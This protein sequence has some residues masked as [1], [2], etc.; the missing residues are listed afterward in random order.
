M[1]RINYIVLLLACCLLT[2]TSCLDDLNTTPLEGGLLT[3]PEAAWKKA[4]TY[5][6]FV[7]KIY[8]CFAM[9]GNNGPNGLDDIVANDQGEATFLRSYWNLQQLTTDEAVCAWDDD[10]L[11]GLMF[12]NWT[13]GNRFTNLTYNRILMTIAYCNEYLRQTDNDKLAERN[14]DPALT[15]KIQ[16][17]RAEV[18]AIRAIKYFLLMDLFAN[19]PFV[20]E[21]MPVGVINQFPEQ[22]GRDFFFPRIES[23]LKAV[24]NQLPEKSA[25]TYGRMNNPTIWMV[26]AKMYLNAEVYI[27]EKKYTEAITYLTKITGAGYTLDPVY[28]NMFGADNDRSPEIIFPVVFDGQKTTSYGGTTYLMAGAYNPDDMEPEANFGL[29]QAWKGIRAKETLSALF[30]E[31]DKR[32]LFWTTGR[33]PE[34]ASLYDFNSGY[35]VV[36]YTNKK[37]D[38]TPGSNPAFPD[39]DFPFFRLADAY[40]MY[41]EAVLRGGEG[42]DRD[43]ALK[44]VNELQKRA[45][46]TEIKD[47]ELSLDFLLEERARELYWEGHR[48]T[49]L[50][51]FNKFT[52]NYRWPWKNGVYLGTTNI[53]DIY[54]L[55]PVPDTELSA[56]PNIKQNKGY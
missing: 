53:S 21:D 11:S 42:G 24:E 44:Y 7:A 17:Y 47:Y 13:S 54:K 46:I 52:A 5:E 3:T 39:T 22:K 35:S 56:N 20:T 1:K 36:K 34:C 51:R 37:S 38:G 32:A 43:L 31:G 14:I 12:C 28:K 23:E 25:S 48:R 27:G 8:A 40:L 18:R 45:G 10:G 41:A 55:F 49:D 2:S 30:A 16:T 50:I 19:V 26:L 9:S 15:D 33:T 4:E 29:N 6:Q